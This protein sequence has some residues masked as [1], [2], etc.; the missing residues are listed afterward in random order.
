[1]EPSV[2]VL[3]RKVSSVSWSFPVDFALRK[4]N[5]L[6]VMLAAWWA[7][8][9]THVL[10]AAAAI[11]SVLAEWRSYKESCP[12]PHGEKIETEMTLYT[13]FLYILELSWELSQGYLSRRESV[14]GWSMMVINGKRFVVWHVF[15]SL[16]WAGS[17][18]S[19]KSAAVDCDHFNNN[20]KLSRLDGS[21]WLILFL[22]AAS[23][24]LLVMP[25]IMWWMPGD[26]ILLM[27]NNNMILSCTW[28]HILHS[29]EV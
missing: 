10:S 9:F 27:C 11:Y 2:S 24:A 16:S 28:I 20:C 6:V 1:M 3:E 13:S 21:R 17:W 12:V 5:W 19:G 29:W 25:P 8:L 15:G 18:I 23:A 26:V 22:Q 14:G 4:I 7:P